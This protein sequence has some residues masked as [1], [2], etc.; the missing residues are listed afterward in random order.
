MIRVA[1]RALFTGI[2]GLNATDRSAI[3]TTRAQTLPRKVIRGAAEIIMYFKSTASFT[4][5]G[6]TPFVECETARLVIES[7]MY[8]LLWTK[9]EYCHTNVSKEA[10]DNS[11]F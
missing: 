6:S 7:G 8:L 9:H 2:D 4:N 3:H 11:V 5:H 1:P 10:I